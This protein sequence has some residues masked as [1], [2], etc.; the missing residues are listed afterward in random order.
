MTKN[1]AA[2]R[3]F[4]AR[5]LKALNAQLATQAEEYVQ[6]RAEIDRAVSDAQKK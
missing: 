1:E 3:G 2:A 5:L 6:H 4:D